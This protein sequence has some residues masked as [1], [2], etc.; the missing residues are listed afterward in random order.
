MNKHREMENEQKM[1]EENRK[2]RRYIQVHSNGL[3]C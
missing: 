3:A 2:E 1:K